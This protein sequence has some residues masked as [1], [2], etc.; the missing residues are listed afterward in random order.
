MVTSTQVKLPW[1][2]PPRPQVYKNF[3]V[4][5]IT[6]YVPP[7]WCSGLDRE[8]LVEL[9]ELS[10]FDCIPDEEI[11]RFLRSRKHNVRKTIPLLQDH[12]RFLKKYRPNLILMS[13]LRNAMSTG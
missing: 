5:T 11:V 12:V 8:G 9:R 6:A 13:M 10:E 1:F 4:A 7:K 2:C 3:A